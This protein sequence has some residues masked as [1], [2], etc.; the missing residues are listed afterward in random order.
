MNSFFENEF[1][2]MHLCHLKKFID[3]FE[4]ETYI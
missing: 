4:R 1:L 2:M 3:G